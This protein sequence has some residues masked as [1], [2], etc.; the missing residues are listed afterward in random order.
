MR[1]DHGILA[2]VRPRHRAV[3]NRGTFG[4]AYRRLPTLAPRP[5]KRLSWD[6]NQ[7]LGP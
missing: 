2:L 4:D 7:F 1:P 6:Q 5:Y 3:S